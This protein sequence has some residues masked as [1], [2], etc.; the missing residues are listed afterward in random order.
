[1]TGGTAAELA[2]RY[3]SISAA[4]TASLD[5][6]AGARGASVET[7]MEVAG[8]QV[9]RCAWALIGGRRE[10]IAV[11]AGHGNNGGDGAVAAVYLSAWG[12]PVALHVVG[13]PGSAREL[14]RRQLE[15]ADA[16]GVLITH[17]ADGREPVLLDG[18]GL[19]IDALIGIGLRSA[20]RAPYAEVIAALVTPRLSPILS[21][22]VPSGMEATSGQAFEPCVRAAATCTLAAVKS[23]LWEDDASM[24]V[25]TLHVADIGMPSDAWSDCRLVAPTDV[26]GGALIE[27]ARG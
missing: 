8:W 24:Y 20:P 15:R 27:V 19:I 6:A 2:R 5:A 21:V 1:M 11:V 18:A 26:T 16:A 14:V 4:T 3:G 23:G 7:L 22:D 13:R 9:A 25:G 12:C 10:R 17:L